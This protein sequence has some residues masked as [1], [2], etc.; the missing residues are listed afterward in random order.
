HSSLPVKLWKL[1][2]NKLNGIDL[3]TLNTTHTNI[4]KLQDGMIGAQIW[5]VF[6]F[7]DAQNKDAVR[8]TL[9]QI[10]IIQRMCKTYDEF[11]MVSSSQG[12]ENTPNNKIA[13]LMGIDGGHSIDSSLATL[14]MYYELGV[15]YMAL[16]NAC[17]TPW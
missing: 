6:A 3:R 13:C 1:Y 17:N 8:L 5:S 10:D 14:R 9:E 2:R 7:C 11:E 15:R 12:I 4:Q 16:T